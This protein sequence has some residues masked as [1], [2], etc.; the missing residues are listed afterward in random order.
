MTVYQNMAL[1][2]KIKKVPKQEMRRR[3]QEAAEILRLEDLLHKRPRELSGGQ[4]QRVAMGR[5]IVRQPRAFLMDEPLSNLDA[6]L[7]VQMRS[8]ILRIQKELRVTTIYVTH[9][10]TE[11]MTLGDRVAVLRKGVLQQ[12]APPQELYRRPVNLFVAGFIGSPAMNMVEAKLVSS[13]GSLQVEFGSHRL[14]VP[15]EVTTA[16]PA[17]AGLAGRTVVL[18]IRPEHM[19]D[20]ALAGGAP[21]DSRI[22]MVTDLREEMGSE[23]LLHF[24]VDAAPVLMDDTRELASDRGSEALKD[25]QEQVSKRKSTFIAKANAETDAGVAE[26]REIFVDTRKLHF[27]DAETGEAIYGER[28]RERV[29]QGSPA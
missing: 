1:S 12:L 11:A 2:L 17:L 26:R 5:A 6:A 28:E 22:S 23:V 14:R 19:E 24:T 20:A 13:D 3:V 21:E 15:D 29:P 10:Q 7:R 18:G 8:E 16:R 25:L 27:F 4:R 9:D